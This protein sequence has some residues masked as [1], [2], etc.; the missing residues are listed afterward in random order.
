[1]NITKRK[2]IIAGN[3]KMNFVDSLKF[4]EGLSGII[5]ADGAEVVIC[6]PHTFLNYIGADAKKYGVNALTGAQDISAFGSGAYT[7]EVSG[8]MLTHAGVSYCIVGHSE[9]RQY[10]GETNELVAEKTLR[11]H[12]N[13]LIPIVCVGES[14]EQREQGKTF[15]LI[16]KQVSAVLNTLSEEQLDKTVFAYEPIWAIGTGKTATA[17]QAE[18]VCGAIRNRIAKKYSEE[19]ADTISILYGGSMNEKNAAELLSQPDIDGGLIGGASLD[20]VKFSAIIKAVETAGAR[21]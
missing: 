10:H 12:E 11:C 16:S 20:P 6:A 8:E 15:T 19:K 1:M 21:V 13:G 9:R 3:W 18:E 17:E 7:G 4:F 14:L 2:T 5:I